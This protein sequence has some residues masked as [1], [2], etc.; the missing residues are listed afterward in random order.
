[1]E[2]AFPSPTRTRRRLV[3]VVTALLLT[4]FV[5]T[6]F[7]S[8]Y[9]SLASLQEKVTGA[10][11]PLTSDNIY[12]AAQK[13]LLQPALI[14]SLMANDSFVVDW[15]HGGEK[16]PAQIVRYLAKTRDRFGTMT[17]FFVS[18]TTG[19]YYHAGGVLKTISPDDPRDR[20]FYRV[21]AMAAPYETNV[22]PDAA[23]NDVMTAFINYRMV[24][25]KGTFL[26][27]IGVGMSIKSLSEEIRRYQ[28]LFNRDIY[29]FAPD[30]KLT[31]AGAD[32]STVATV[33]DLP[34]W[35]R[36]HGEVLTKDHSAFTYEHGGA[37]HYLNSRFIPE[38]G[39]YLVIHGVDDQERAPIRRALLL[40]LLV[41]AAIAG[42]V[43][44]LTLATVNRYQ[45]RVEELASID[46]LT[47]AF[48]RLSFDLLLEQACKEAHRTGEP[49]TVALFDLDHFKKINDTHGHLAGD[50]TLV[51]AVKAIKGQLREADVLCRWGG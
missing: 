49:F 12:S 42:V 7:G 35:D 41:A 10:E 16:D 3:V 4:G 25:D 14:S 2:T 8:Y 30:G 26:G 1:M 31:L 6:S 28:G 29:F 15:V 33:D 51:A 43:I 34:G 44:A 39:W 45:A 17:A 9:A 21:R 47:G 27:A 11:L 5:A 38:L 46:P 36:R 37:T 22:D 50:A 48:N 13:S 24:D 40:N 18:D 20:W 19:L 32:A 23:H